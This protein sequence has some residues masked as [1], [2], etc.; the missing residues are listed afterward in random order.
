MDSFLRSPD[1]C[2]CSSRGTGLP[3]CRLPPELRQKSPASH[4]G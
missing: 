1:W 2:S 4:I 3:E